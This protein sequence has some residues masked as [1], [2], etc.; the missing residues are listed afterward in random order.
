[1][2]FPAIIATHQNF[3]LPRDLNSGPLGLESDAQPTEPSDHILYG[4][5]KHHR[6]CDI[7]INVCMFIENILLVSLDGAVGVKNV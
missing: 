7:S 3:S 2:S 4:T 5:L 6:I 1:M